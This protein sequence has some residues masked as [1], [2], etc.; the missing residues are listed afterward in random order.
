[1]DFLTVKEMAEKWNI[2]SRMVTV[3]CQTGRIPGAI[4]KGNLWLVPIDSEKPLDKRKNN[5]K[6]KECTANEK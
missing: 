2:T 4:K 1:M 3:Y 6:A 5:G